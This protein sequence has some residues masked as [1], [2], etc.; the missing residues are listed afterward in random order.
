MSNT[1]P[2]AGEVMPAHAMPHIQIHYLNTSLV[3]NTLVS[4]QSKLTLGVQVSLKPLGSRKHVATLVTLETDDPEIIND[5]C[6]TPVDLA[7]MDAVY[8]LTMYG[9]TVLTPTAIIRAMSGDMEQELTSAMRDALVAAITKLMHLWIQI[10]C[11]AEY[12]ARGIIAEDAELEPLSSPLLPVEEVLVQPANHSEPI[13]GYQL[14]VV[15]ALYVYASDI[16]NIANVQADVL[17]TPHVGNSIEMI[18]LKRYLIRRIAAMRNKRNAV[19][20]N[21]IIYERHDNRAH[22]AVGLYANMGYCKEDYKN[23]RDK[24]RKIHISVCAILGDLVSAG[25]IKGYSELDSWLGRRRSPG[26]VEIQL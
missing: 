10:D 7:V 16:R 23:W 12:R 21:S 5:A 18:K 24:R 19:K 22:A 26:G 20:S 8:T 25:Y 17:R 13:R 14:H 9:C 2:F 6:I 11:Q 15:S 1:N 3:A 4:P